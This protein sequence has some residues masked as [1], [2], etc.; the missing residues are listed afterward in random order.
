MVAEELGFLPGQARMRYGYFVA[1]NVRHNNPLS[2]MQRTV[3]CEM[4]G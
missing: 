1:A 2:E 3:E 4:P